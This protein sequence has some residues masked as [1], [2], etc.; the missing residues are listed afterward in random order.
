MRRTIAFAVLFG[1]A[2]WDMGSTWAADTLNYGAWDRTRWKEFVFES[3]AH[4]KQFINDRL[5]NALAKEDAVAVDL[6]YALG[7]AHYLLGEY[8][9][10]INSYELGMERLR[11]ISDDTEG[12]LEME[13]ALWN[14]IGVNWEVLGEFA[15]AESALGNSRRIDAQ[16]GDLQGAWTTAINQGLLLSRFDAHVPAISLLEETVGY[17][18]EAALMPELALARLNLAV[19]KNSANLP[20]AAME[21]ESAKSLFQLLNDTS[22]TIRALV[23]LG[24]IQLGQSDFDHLRATLDTAEKWHPDWLPPQ[25]EFYLELLRANECLQRKAY[26]E[27]AGH[28]DRAEVLTE[29]SPNLRID[30][31][32]LPTAITLA[33]AQGDAEQAVDLAGKFRKSVT[34]LFAI[35][36][37]DRLAEHQELNDR[38]AQLARIERLESDLRVSRW[39]FL[40]IALTSGLLLLVA[41]MRWRAKRNQLRSNRIIFGFVRD[42]LRP[43]LEV[44]EEQGPEAPHRQD[45]ILVLRYREIFQSV[46]DLVEQQEVFLNPNLTLGELA[47]LANSNPRYVS[48]AIK[49]EQG[50]GFSEYINGIRIN[51]AQRILLDP[52]NHHLSFEQITEQCGFSSTRTFYRQFT[53]QMNMT[54]GEFMRLA[55][56]SED[57]SGAEFKA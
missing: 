44:G 3:P 18:E 2:T 57:E 45:E 54:P 36:R 16:R 20:E 30:S 42:R 11:S 23:T 52:H 56:L 46:R 43:N 1:L 25:V 32:Y 13:S 7:L 8:I 50:V 6:A 21:A 34:N 48:H 26:F 39:M 29:A 31:D 55:R 41:A 37:A 17:F 4:A 33:V 9:L 27:A 15:K 49:Q 51:R 40:S 47:S 28:L 22:G 38:A 12:A 5:P 10:S 53:R 19:A 35:N 24:Q 14:N